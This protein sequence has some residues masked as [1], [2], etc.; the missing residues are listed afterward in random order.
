M[1]CYA[2]HEATFGLV[3]S[4]LILWI[5]RLLLGLETPKSPFLLGRT[6]KQR[7]APFSRVYR[8]GGGVR[9]HTSG[10]HTPPP[11][12]LEPPLIGTLSPLRGERIENTWMEMQA[13]WHGS[14]HMVASQE[15]HQIPGVLASVVRETV[16]MFSGVS[17][18]HVRWV[19]Q[20]D[21]D[22]ERERGDIYR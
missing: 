9:K 5:V 13:D 16:A 15:H 19:G 17:H 4:S 7:L 12:G 2:R 3:R 1:S 21:V 22:I 18:Q 20:A 14:A 10:T 8:W 6:P 11:A